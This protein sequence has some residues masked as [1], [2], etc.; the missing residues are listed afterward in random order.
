VTRAAAPAVARVAVPVPLPRLFDYL[1]PAG[2]SL[3][4]AGSRVLVPFGRR[5]V[6][7]LVMD[8]GHADPAAGH[9]LKPIERVLDP[10]LIAAGQLEL[11][12]WCAR[13]YAFAPGEAVNLL[14]PGALRR[15]RAFRAP[16]PAGVALTEAGRDAELSRAPRQAELRERLLEGPLERDKLLADT[17]AG[18]DVLRRMERQG[19]VRGV[20]LEQLPAARPGPELNAEQRAAVAAVLR[21]RRRF[22]PMLLAGVTGSGKTE[23]YLAAARRILDM[24]RQV[25]ILAPEIGLT[26]QLVR[27]IE[28]RLG[29]AAWLYH[30]DLSEGERLATWQAA[31]AGRARVVVATR[32]G[33]FL[34][35]PDPG[36][37]IVDE[38]H[39][40]SFKQAEGARYHGRDVAVLRARLA[41]VPILLGSAT[42]SLESLHNVERDRYELLELPRR[43]GAARQ[44][45]WRI[46]DQRG[47]P[48]GLDAGLIEAMQRHLDEGGQV[49]LYRNRRGYAPVLMCSE[50]GWQADC[51]RCDAH[52]T[53]HRAGKNL[54]CHH[55]GSQRPQ[56]PRCPEC[57]SPG[58]IALG[59][60]TER[61]EE[62]VR[63]RFPDV[64]VHRVDR[65]AMGGKHDFERLL[66]QVRGGEPCILVGTQMLAKGHHLP[67][68]TLAA[69][70]DVDQALFS[71][72][73]RA[74]ERL[75]QTVAQVAGRAG[76]GDRAGEFLLLTRHPEH[77]LL[78]ALGRGDYRSYAWALLE[79]RVQA[80]LPPAS[81]LALLRAEAHEAAAAR[82]FLRAASGRLAGRGIDVIGPLPAIM[83]R[84]GG[85]W[86]FQ[87]WLQAESRAALVNR[88]SACLP[89]LHDMD[90]ARRARWHFDV[91]PLEL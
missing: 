5:R 50:C 70:L 24:N 12:D 35:L 13:Y 14:L 56:P 39:D 40:S 84:R 53:F 61:L 72:D 38:E 29:E 74:P 77:P 33:V 30:S 3:P 2:Q 68:V 20:E 23:V 81:A 10:G 73:F 59:A 42:P 43:A 7:G 34:P 18:S 21:R 91:D 17:G 57:A 54:Q 67:G 63:E 25:L 15:V 79:E 87:L 36:L 80:Q 90:S 8:Q 76:R 82:D 86:R 65:D 64:P 60:G 27:R 75:G 78:E 4:P 47:S 89:A 9:T 58:L 46:L 19:L 37:I 45:R 11:I 28:A 62:A 85:Y 71:A 16:A 26:P 44:P 52:L 69:V 83:S 32:S 49:L 51:Q 31:R 66:E 48:A 22:A 1:A 88:I 6:V 41:G 55:C